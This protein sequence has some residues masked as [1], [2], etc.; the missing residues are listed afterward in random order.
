[1]HQF[2]W[3]Q[4]TEPPSLPTTLGAY[5]HRLRTLYDYRTDADYTARAMSQTEANDGLN[6]ARDILTL[7]AQAKGL[8]FASS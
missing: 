4:W 1:M 7:V 5:R 6:L 8:P 2:C 3:G